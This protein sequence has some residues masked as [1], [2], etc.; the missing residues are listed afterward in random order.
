MFQRC[1]ANRLAKLRPV[2]AD[3]LRRVERARGEIDDVA[4][5]ASE[6]VVDAYIHIYTSMFENYLPSIILSKC[7]D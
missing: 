4:R 5:S 2:L 7:I 1:S 3:V 6:G